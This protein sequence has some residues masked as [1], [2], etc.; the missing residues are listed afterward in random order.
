MSEPT[1]N[2]TTVN[3]DGTVTRNEYMDSVTR[4]MNFW[5]RELRPRKSWCGERHRYFE[6]IIPEYVTPEDEEYDS[7]KADFD[8]VPE[9]ADYAT[10]LRNIRARILW[11][12]KS[13]TISL[14]MADEMFRASGM[15]VY[16]IPG[17]PVGTRLV[18]YFPR[19]FFNASGDKDAAMEWAKTNFAESIVQ[20]L[21]GKPMQENNPYV[22]G[23][24]VFDGETDIEFEPQVTPTTIRDEDVIRPSRA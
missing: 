6:A 11:Y 3:L 4:L 14:A 20:A 13:G 9:N 22:P 1:T 19:V 2:S 8:K 17:K 21:D 23:S 12:A 7:G 18:A 16:T 15:P 24:V 10:L 5:H